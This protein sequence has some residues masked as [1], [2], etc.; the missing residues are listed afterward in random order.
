MWAKGRSRC[1]DNVCKSVSNLLLNGIVRGYFFR[2]F[3]TSVSSIIIII[4]NKKGKKFF[5][6]LTLNRK[7]SYEQMEEREKKK[8]SISRIIP[9][10]LL[11]ITPDNV[12]S[13]DVS[14]RL[15][16]LKQSEEQD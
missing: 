5:E 14:R 15:S 6:G 8:E 9:V 10:T 11:K 4:I 12:S 7:N 16:R 1:D 2:S 3:E 13:S